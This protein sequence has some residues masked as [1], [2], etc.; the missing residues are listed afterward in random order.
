MSDSP[1]QAPAKH[2]AAAAP[3]RVM[4][5]VAHPDDADFL[6][7]GSVAK[8]TREGCEVTLVVVTDGSKGSDDPEML[9]EKL[10]EIRQVEQRAAARVLGT[11]EVVF[12]GYEDGALVD[13][14]RLRRDLTRV[15]R[16]HQP[17]RVVTMD[18]TARFHGDG[19]VNHPDHIA[20]GT[21]ASWAVSLFAR[22]RPSFRDLLA[23]GLEPY[24]V[25]ELYLGSSTEP[26]VWVDIGSTIDLKIAALREHK[27]QLSPDHLDE[28][29]REWA[30]GAAKASGNASIEYA[31]SFRRLELD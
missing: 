21:V 6:A 3:S 18:P 24:K 26:N 7:A 1:N 8:W 23:E 29:M 4:V 25:R 20:A 14:P 28:M 30:R 27:S 5:I 13:S 10:I 17:E 11:K 16:L 31:E 15:I 19:Y 2:D 22:N 9:P 12:L